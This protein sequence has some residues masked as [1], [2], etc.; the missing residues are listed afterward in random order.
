MRVA[1]PSAWFQKSIKKSQTAQPDQSSGLLSPS[2]SHPTV[3]PSASNP[4]HL[5]SRANARRPSSAASFRSVY[6]A[7]SDTQR[8]TLTLRTQDFHPHPFAAMA[9]AP[10]PVVSSHDSSEEEE[11]CPVCL[12]P[13]SFSFRLPGEKPHIVPEC[14]HALHEVSSFPISPP[15]LVYGRLNSVSYAPL[16]TRSHLSMRWADTHVRSFILPVIL[17]GILATRGF[18]VPFRPSLAASHHFPS[19]FFM[20]VLVI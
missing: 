16:R 12:E 7:A 10:L 14:G 2:T 13:L 18:C 9:H 11:E 5:N 19:S 17:D 8:S 15:F 3:A 1:H 6:T 20:G 4:S